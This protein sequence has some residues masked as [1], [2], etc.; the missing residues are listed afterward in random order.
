MPPT[1][2]DDEVV[3]ELLA[4]SDRTQIPPWRIA[5]LAALSPACV[6]QILTSRKLPDRIGPRRY[7]T[8]FLRLNSKAQS[9][10]EVRLCR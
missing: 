2:N 3:D 4:F 7:L 9:V 8:E 5:Y 6:K 1:R 10:H